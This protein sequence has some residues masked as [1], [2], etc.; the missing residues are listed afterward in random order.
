MRGSTSLLSRA[1]RVQQHFDPQLENEL[2][3]DVLAYR[4]ASPRE[5]QR[6]GDPHGIVLESDLLVKLA[7]RLRRAP[8]VKVVTV[9]RGRDPE[10]DATMLALVLLNTLIHIR[11][12]AEA[13]DGC[14]EDPRPGVLLAIVRQV[15]AIGCTLL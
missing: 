5:R 1:L 12:R 7:A 8:W 4:T 13:Y 11:N 2:F 10:V 3:R 14:E 9:A 15:C 6:L